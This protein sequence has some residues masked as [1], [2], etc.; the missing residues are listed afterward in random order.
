MEDLWYKNSVIYSLDLETFMDANND[1]IGDFAGLCDRLDYLNAMGIDTVWLAPFQP[2][3]NKDNGY[4]V[5]DY[6]GVDPRHGSSGD[7][8]EF[9]H[10]AKQLGIKVIIDLVVNHTSDKHPWFK[11]ARSSKDNPK[12]DWYVWSDKRPSDW[13]EGMVFPGVQ[14]STWTLDKETG[15]YYFHRFH[16]YEPD[17]NTDNPAVREEIS[18]IMG[19]WLQLGVAG[20]RVDAVPFILESPAP[21]SKKSKMN[22]DY[23]RQ[24]RRF[25]QWRKGDAVLLGEANVLPKETKHYFGEN[26]DGIHLMFNFFVNQYLFY[27]LATT[28][29]RPLVKALQQ[30]KLEASTSQWAHFLRNH[31]EL[32]LGRL[33]EEERNQVFA[34]YAPDKNMQ[35]YFRGIRRRL[36]PMLGSRQQNELAYSIMFSLPGTPVLRYGDELGMGDNMELEDR[37]SVRTPMQWSADHQA[38]FSKADKLVHPVIDDGYY[39]YMHINVE[40]QRR[41]PDSMLNWMTAMIRLRREC[42]EIGNGDWEILDTGYHHILGMRYHWRERQLF[43]WH[44]FSDHP[45]ELV[46]TS[47]VTGK[48][49][50]VDLMNNIESIEDDKGRHTITLEAYGYR[51]FRGG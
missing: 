27:A 30:T 3:P 51:W 20:F 35:L 10:R 6:Y 17:L 15:T 22:Y 7:F 26:S 46:V 42:P 45:Q 49:R 8:V 38:G 11:E 5:Q 41:D 9:M 28:D 33:T 34:K 2:T 23:L 12:R 1:G 47:K 18:R 14:R 40:S 31:D 44:N 32:D 39:S 16:E 19:Y 4:D 13:N 21:G 43:I 25:L 36:G 29:V 24:M 37:D 50:L 48:G